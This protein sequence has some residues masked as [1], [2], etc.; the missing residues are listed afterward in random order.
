MKTPYT[1]TV[2]RVADLPTE[3]RPPEVDE[4]LDELL[5]HDPDMRSIMWLAAEDSEVERQA[6]MQSI[7][8]GEYDVFVIPKQSS[9]DRD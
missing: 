3:N 7:E 6:W 2:I 4:L 5:E 1:M 8:L 9:P